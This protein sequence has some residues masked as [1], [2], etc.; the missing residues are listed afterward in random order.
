VFQG[1]DIRVADD[2]ITWIENKDR[3][4]IMNARGS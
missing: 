1:G 3:I 4:D 2:R